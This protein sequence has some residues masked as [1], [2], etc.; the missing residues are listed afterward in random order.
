MIICA[1]SDACALFAAQASWLQFVWADS[2][3][4]GDAA[5]PA[6]ETQRETER[7]KETDRD[8]ERQK[9]AER[10]ADRDGQTD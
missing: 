4:T 10:E 9:Q 3:E 6:E 8:R 1:P 7:E 5:V 2:S